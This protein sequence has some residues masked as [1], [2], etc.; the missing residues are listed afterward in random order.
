M[1][2]PLVFDAARV[3]FLSMSSQFSLGSQCAM[4]SRMTL[5]SARRTTFP[6]RNSVVRPGFTS[7]AYFLPSRGHIA[8]GNLFLPG[9]IEPNASVW[10]EVANLELRASSP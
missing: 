3:S 8:D 4:V 10:L 1:G 5:F 7:T 6:S 9:A 2:L